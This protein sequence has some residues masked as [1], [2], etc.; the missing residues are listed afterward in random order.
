MYI[1]ICFSVVEPNGRTNRAMDNSKFKR[2]TVQLIKRVEPKQNEH[3]L[4]SNNDLA[5]V[6]ILHKK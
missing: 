5:A 2:I 4:F 3:Q 1:Y 6:L